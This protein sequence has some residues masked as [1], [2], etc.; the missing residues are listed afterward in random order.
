MMKKVLLFIGFAT[1]GLTMTACQ[2]IPQRYNGNAGYKVE[3]KTNNSAIISYTLAV[4]PNHALNQTKL[5]NACKKVLTES[6]NYSVK[7]LS[8]DEIINPANTPQSAGINIGHSQT[9]FG[10]ANTN[11]GDNSAS[12]T[13]LGIHPNTLTVIRY[14]C[15]PK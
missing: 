8:T 7:V 14:E 11:T 5:E 4:Q 2:N 15:T 12:R 1:V 10:L 3:S 6:L 13:A 9:T